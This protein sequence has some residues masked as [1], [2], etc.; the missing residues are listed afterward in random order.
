LAK[1][2]TFFALPD[3]LKVPL[4]QA[5]YDRATR[6]R[7]QYAFKTVDA[8]H[9]AAAVEAHCDAFLTHDLALARFRDIAVEL[10]T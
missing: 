1:F 4:T 7:A 2:D 5:V 6:A 8:I 3:V 10:L 9:L